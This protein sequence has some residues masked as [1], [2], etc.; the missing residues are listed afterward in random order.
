MED[1]CDVC[2]AGTSEG[3][4]EVGAGDGHDGMTL[5]VDCAGIVFPG[6]REMMTACCPICAEGLSH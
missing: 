5:C 2:F 6:L 1:L 3:S 4:I